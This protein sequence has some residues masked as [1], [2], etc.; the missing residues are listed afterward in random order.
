MLFRSADLVFEVAPRITRIAQGPLTES[1]NDVSDP[2][3][4][5]RHVVAPE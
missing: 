3:G 1:G 2:L 5:D 4:P